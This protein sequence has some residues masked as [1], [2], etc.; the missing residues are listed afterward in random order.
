MLAFGGGKGAG[1][2][3]RRSRCWRG[4]GGGSSSGVEVGK[5]KGGME[6]GVGVGQ[7]TGPST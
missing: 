6:Q 5:N 1:C 2:D 3:M 7:V 4:G